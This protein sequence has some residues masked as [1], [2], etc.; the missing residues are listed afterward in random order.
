MQAHTCRVLVKQLFPRT[1]PMPNCSESKHWMGPAM[2]DGAVLHKHPSDSTVE[3]AAHTGVVQHDS[4]CDWQQQQACIKAIRTQMHAGQSLGVEGYS[5]LF[6][7]VGAH[8]NDFGDLVWQALL[9]LWQSY[10]Y[11][12]Q[13]LQ[14]GGEVWMGWF[15]CPRAIQQGW[16]PRGTRPTRVSRVLLPSRVR[17]ITQGR[18]C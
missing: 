6:R 14:G 7:Y 8:Q 17:K 1:A 12:H 15:A 9:Q 16:R 2:A 10:L 11:R 18:G 13:M 3:P 4:E 5:E